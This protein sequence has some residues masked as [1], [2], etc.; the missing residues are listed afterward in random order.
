MAREEDE[1]SKEAARQAR[2]YHDPEGGTLTVWLGP[3]EEEVVCT[4]LEVDIVLMKDRN[5]LVIGVEI[6][7]LESQKF[8]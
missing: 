4:Q 1:G 7:G 8:R 6:L 3:P 2:A 5:G